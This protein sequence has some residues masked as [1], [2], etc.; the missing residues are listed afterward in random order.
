MNENND[1]PGLSLADLAEQRVRYAG[2]V[3]SAESPIQRELARTRLMALERELKVRWLEAVSDAGAA[4]PP[5]A[6]GRLAH[7]AL[8]LADAEAL[9]RGVDD[10]AAA[11]ALAHLRSALEGIRALVDGSGL[12]TV[13]GGA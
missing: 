9:L 8:E 1:V 6:V 2:A 12:V 4:L 10:R 5:S 3:A 11:L 13:G 7:A